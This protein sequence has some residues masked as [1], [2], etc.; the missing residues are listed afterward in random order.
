MSDQSTP[1]EGRWVRYKPGHTVL[2][3]NRN[4]VVVGRNL[5]RGIATQGIADLR[6]AWIFIL[7]HLPPQTEC[8]RMGSDH[9]QMTPIARSQDDEF[10]IEY[11]EDGR[12]RLCLDTSNPDKLPR[13]RQAI[14]CIEKI[15]RLPKYPTR[16]ADDLDEDWAE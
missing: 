8:V 4:A 2:E 6:P 5:V 11:Y 10:T 16:Q 3:F 12:Y 9:S 7:P 13:F 1:E 15:L 14:D